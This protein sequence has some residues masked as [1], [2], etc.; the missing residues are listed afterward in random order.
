[1]I[2]SEIWNMLTENSL[3]LIRLAMQALKREDEL[4][5]RNG[6]NTLLSQQNP[7]FINETL[8]RQAV[9]FKM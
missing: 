3:S 2:F 5:V 6:W 7:P 1:M 8:C 9:P 4:G